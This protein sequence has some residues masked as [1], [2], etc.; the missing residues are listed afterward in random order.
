MFTIE[1][2]VHMN[3]YMTLLDELRTIPGK[4]IYLVPTSPLRKITLPSL[5]A[6]CVFSLGTCVLLLVCKAQGSLLGTLHIA[7]I[8][9]TLC[10]SIVIDKESI[11]NFLRRS[12]SGSEFHSLFGPR[13][14]FFY[15]F[16]FR[17][18]IEKKRY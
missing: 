8:S 10:F 5:G 15:C 3:I 14:H 6:S 12:L 4:L 17:R 9:R 1:P 2:S 13:N 18:K 16:F 7:R 11:K